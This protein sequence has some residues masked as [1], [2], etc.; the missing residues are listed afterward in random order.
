M[1]NQKHLPKSLYG[2]DPQTLVALLDLQKAFHGRQIFRWLVR[3]V[4]SFE[5]MTDLPKAERERLSNMMSSASS[6]EVYSMDRDVSGAMKMGIRL[7]DSSIVEAVLLV[8]NKGRHTACLS[9]QVGC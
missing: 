1:E 8:D 5:A 6:S 9:S 2:L 3:G 7:H 4:T